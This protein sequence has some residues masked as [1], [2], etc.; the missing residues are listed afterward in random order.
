MNGTFLKA[1]FVMTIFLTAIIPAQTKK[2]PGELY[3]EAQ[4]AY[5]VKDYKTLLELYRQLER[6]RPYNKVVMYNL[7]GVYSLNKNKGQ[8]L[9]YLRKTLPLNATETI[10]TDPDFLWLQP[11]PEFKKIVAD[12]VLLRAPV[13]NSETAFV[14]AQRDLHPESI[15][16]DPKS[17]R[18]YIGSV[19]HQKIVWRDQEGNLHDFVST[20]QDGLD[21]VMGLKIDAERRLLWVTT[22]AIP[23][24]TGYKPENKGRTAIAGFNLETGRCVGKK[25]LHEETI[26]ML[27]DLAIHPDGDIYATDSSANIVYRYHPATDE[28][29]AII[30]SDSFYSLQGLDFS[31]DGRFL[32]IEEYGSGV[33]VAGVK[34]KKILWKIQHSDDAPLVGIDGLYFYKNS[35]VG[36]QNGVFPMR[37]SQFFLD[38]DFKKVERAQVLERNNPHFNEPTLGVLAEGHL[39]Y[40]ANSQWKHYEKDGTIFPFQKLDDIV[41]LKLPLSGPVF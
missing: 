12:A 17:G 34:E 6:L 41:I 15:A 38:K 23:H 33:Y 13:A 36:I 4:K 27:G 22:V 18:F 24:M 16:F 31:G 5:Q 21:A 37:V 10:A 26:H 39:Y 3:A 40:I 1:I 30:A 19:H 20:G 28:L 8:A 32:F 11:L 9:E 29:E 2:T 7:A 25:I 14:I 35:L